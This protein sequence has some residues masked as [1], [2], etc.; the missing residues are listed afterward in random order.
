MLSWEAFHIKNRQVTE[1]NKKTSGDLRGSPRGD[2]GLTGWMW[3]ECN[4][5]DKK[6]YRVLSISAVKEIFFPGE[7]FHNDKLIH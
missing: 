3:V 4:W 2:P 7:N 6:I 1:H 5:V